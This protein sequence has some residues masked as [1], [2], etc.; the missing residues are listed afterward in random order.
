MME[1]ILEESSIRIVLNFGA[2][3]VMVL[4]PTRVFLDIFFDFLF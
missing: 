3:W 4:I 1:Y 2:I